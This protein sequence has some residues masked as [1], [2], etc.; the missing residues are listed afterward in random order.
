MVLIESGGLPPGHPFEDLT[1]LNFVAILTVLREL[2]RNDLQDYDPGIYE[3]LPRNRRN[4][5]ADFVV[6]GGFIRQPG[7]DRPYRA[8]LAFNMEIDDREMA[9]CAAGDPRR[10]SIVEIGDARLLGAGRVVDAEGSLLV[11]P[12]EAGVEGWQAR[13]WLSA[14]VLDDLIGLGVGTVYWKVSPRKIAKAASLAREISGAGRA[15][16]V[17]VQPSADLPW[18]KLT[19][20]TREADSYSLGDVLGALIGDQKRVDEEGPDLLEKMFENARSEPVRPAL[21]RGRPASFLLLAPAAGG[22]IDL[23]ITRLSSVFIDGA[24]VGGGQR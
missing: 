16:L 7:F 9:G 14:E 8:D 10:S 18:L 19:G 6:R 3:A 15:R 23:E 20:P 17:T 4:A 1:R 2:A 13:R 24:E 22:E 5:W 12:F 11:A 21:A